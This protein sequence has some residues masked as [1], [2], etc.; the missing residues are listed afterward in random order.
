MGRGVQRVMNLFSS[1]TPGHKNTVRVLFYGQSIT[2]QSWWREVAEDLRRRFPNADLIIENRA[3]G[4]H[5]SQLL[6]KTAEADLY[7][8]YPD[9]LIFHVYGSHVEY[10]NIIRQVRERTT[11]EIVIQTDHVTRDSALTEETDPAKLSTKNWDAFMNHS[12]LPEI[13]R[14]YGAELVDQRTAWKRYLQEN[15][16][17]AASLLKDGV[18]LNDQGCFVMAELVK[19]W[20]RL[21]PAVD[22]RAWTNSV[23]TFEV[24]RDVRSDGDRLEFD[25]IGNRLDAIAPSTVTALNGLEVWIDG[26]R[27]SAIPALRAFSRASAF[28]N[29]S[30]PCLLRIQSEAPLEIEQWTVTLT[31]V[32]D[33]LKNVR[34]T[35][36]GSKTGEDGEGVS[37]NRF[38]SKSKRIVIEP[39]DW[40][41]G[42]CRQ[43]FKRTVEPGFKITWK[44]MPLFHDEFRPASAKDPTVEN[45]LTLAQGLANGPHHLE[46]RGRIGANLAALRVYRPPGVGRSEETPGSKS[47]R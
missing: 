6:V 12:F 33:D 47:P 35:L 21:N 38:V 7:P 20:L 29:S 46:L 22:D 4:G 18:H 30:W 40:N 39:G 28:P 13:A 1:S 26:Q 9:L 37:T 27:P 36:K 14:K 32:S 3:I 8:F 24:G 11:A 16:L 15:K 23:R 5:S 41:L 34:F 2:E 19:P 45:S 10:E 25:F 17:T 43:V 44:V 42:Y 31:G